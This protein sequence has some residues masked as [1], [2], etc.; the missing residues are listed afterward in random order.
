[1]RLCLVPEY[2]RGNIILQG[3]ITT[4]VSPPQSLYGDLQAFFES[5]GIHDMPAVETEALG[6]R[7]MPVAPDHLCKT[8][9]RAAEFGIDRRPRLLTGRIFFLRTKIIRPAEIIFRPRAAD[10][11]EIR[12]AVHK[13][14]YLSFAP[15]AIIMHAIGEVGADVLPLA[16]DAVDQDKIFLIGKRVHPVEL[17]VEIS[18]IFRK[19]GEDIINLVK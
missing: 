15:P 7:I 16:P 19:L 17:G 14:F 3:Q 10:G 8:G 9:I 2:H 5:D 12:I 1:M 4:S 13:E 18:R 11:R 6:D